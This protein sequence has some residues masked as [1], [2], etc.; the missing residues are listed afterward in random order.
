M[1]VIYIYIYM[2][3]VL[4]RENST[5]CGAASSDSD[6]VACSNLNEHDNSTVLPMLDSSLHNSS[7][8]ELEN[9]NSSDS[10]I[11]DPMRAAIERVKDIEVL[12]RTCRLRKLST[13]G[14]RNQLISKILESH[15][16]HK[17]H[18]RNEG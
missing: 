17:Y 12:R 11:F 7:E 13:E 6:Y 9:S 8:R 5:P 15:R 4:S 3:I 16:T 14:T 10:L 2:C 18:T 1:R